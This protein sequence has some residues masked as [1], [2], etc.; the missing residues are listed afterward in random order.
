MPDWSAMSAI[1]ADQLKVL[2][3][4]PAIP[5]WSRLEPMSLTGGDLTPGVQ[6]PV[7]DPL[8]MLGRQ[9]QFDELRGEDGGSPI[10]ATVMGE[11]AHFSRFH[12]S[13]TPESRS[14]ASAAADS[15]ELPAPGTRDSVP[16]EAL[17]EAEVP[18]V[19][20]VRLRA[21]TGA[22]LVRMLRAAGLSSLAQAA[23]AAFAFPQVPGAVDDAAAAGG[24]AARLRLVAG[25]VPDGSAVAAACQGLVGV[26]GA[27]TALP[28]PLAG[29][30]GGGSAKA[31]RVF[32]EWLVWSRNLL[33]APIGRSWDPHRL[34]Y[35]FE[36]QAELSDGPV[37]LDVDEYTGG[38]LDWFHGDLT[39]APRL[40]P[41]PAAP[42]QTRPLADTTMPT[43]VR[44][45]G[46][47]SD[48]L[49]AFEDAAVY[50]GGVQAGRTDL[51]RLAVAEFALAYGVD[52][53]QL[54]IVLPYG[55]ATRF[56]HVRVVDTFGAVIE[57][58]PSKEAASPGWTAFQA[59]AITD[60]GRLSEVFVLAPTVAGV[61]E[62]PPLEEVALFRDEMANLVWGVERI[63]PDRLTG[64]PVD[65][66]R[67]AARITL[68][69][70]APDPDLM[71]D[72]Q[73]VY[74]LMTPVPENWI[75]FVAFREDPSTV[76]AH[77]VLERRPMLRFPENGPVELVNPHGTILLT[78]DDADPATDRLRIAEEE[79]PRDG[80]VVTRTFQSARTVGG[81]SALWIGR[82]A[83]TGRGEGA[84]GLRFDTALPPGGM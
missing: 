33:A 7:A 1:L 13:G 84:S 46:M 12:A 9:W 64:E 26:D 79:V 48:R 67:S 20:P 52:W 69:Q 36:V 2:Q 51:A 18:H 58:R 61:L 80:V 53:F 37:V 56:D 16:L 55:S 40:G 82:R 74:R 71:A 50:L 31:K 44:F 29:V 39:E 73:L 66:A 54:P 60:T 81:G 24:S 57:V 19:L 34:E 83:R 15:V 10:E 28:D 30:G 41:A 62:G 78:A 3:A 68:R 42:G 32:G 59:T 4:E 49:F 22:H 75:P 45:A 38:T 25:R 17:V 14:G 5:T 11:S 65:R 76:R 6:V 27:L 21:Q 77:H 70:P 23:P 35:S 8:W 72:A 43:P 47:P 63:V